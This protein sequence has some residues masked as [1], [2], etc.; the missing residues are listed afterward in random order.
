MQVRQLSATYLGEQDRILVRINT[1]EAEEWR[2]WL[3]RRLTLT[4]W[5]L[6]NQVLVDQLVKLEASVTSGAAADGDMK[7]MLADFRKNEFLQQADFDTPY[8]GAEA[9][10]P[11][12][13]EP[14]LV[15]DVNITPLAASRVALEFIEKP[16]AQA[17]PRSF[18]LELEPRLMQGFLHLVDQA[19]RHADWQVPAVAPASPT[20]DLFADTGDELPDDKPRYLN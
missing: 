18:V 4:L 15:T 19:L 9:R 1:T 2:V 12:G 14:L 3:T 20:G 17:T 13:D 10:L 5:P 11:L 7:K 16:P 6:L 8:E